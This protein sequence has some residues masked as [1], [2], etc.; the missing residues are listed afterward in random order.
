M[1]FLRKGWVRI[2]LLL[3]ADGA[4]VFGAGVIYFIYGCL[5]RIPDELCSLDAQAGVNIYADDG[6]LLYTFN[7][8]INR[9]PLDRVAPH[10]LQAVI[11]TEDADFFTIPT[12]GVAGGTMTFGNSSNRVDI[13]NMTAGTSVEFG[14]AG[15]LNVGFVFPLSLGDNKPFDSEIAVQLNMRR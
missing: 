11:A 7:R 12:P 10:F 5:P 8:N 13:F 2:L 14:D 6:Q 4:L 15:S 1:T 3:A 9:V